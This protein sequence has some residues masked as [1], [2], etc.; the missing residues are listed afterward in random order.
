MP[1]ATVGAEANKDSVRF[2]AASLARPTG[3]KTGTG[4]KGSA[5]ARK[6]KP[7]RLLEDL[8][9]CLR[10]IRARREVQTRR[11][12][13]SINAYGVVAGATC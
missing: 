8:T 5:I 2:A 12:P 1:S 13:V 9:L 11:N 4:D 10:I 7:F 3:T 6:A